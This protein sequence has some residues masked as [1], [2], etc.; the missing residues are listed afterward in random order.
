MHHTSTGNGIKISSLLL[1][2]RLL[3][4]V[5]LIP[6]AL[7]KFLA[8]DVFAAKFDLSTTVSILAGVAELGGGLAVAL[9]ALL[10]AR[11]GAWITWAGVVAIA[12]VQI[13]AI[14]IVHWGAWLYFQGGWEYNFV[15]L[16]LC[17]MLVVGTIPATWYLSSASTSEHNT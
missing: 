7:G 14:A 8:T 6:H 12:I 17:F 3:L 1:I 5:V 9:G 10:A 11:A 16:G 2:P 15:L 13:G 4:I